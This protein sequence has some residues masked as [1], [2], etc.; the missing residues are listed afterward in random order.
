MAEPIDLSIAVIVPAHNA[1]AYLARC[2]TGLMAAGFSTDEIVLVDDA[3][4]DRTVE[5]ARTFNV[6]P[7][8]IS[9]NAGAANAR[10]VGVRATKADIL[11]FVDADVVVHPD[12]RRRVLAFFTEHPQYAA[13]FGSY[14]DDPAAN[15]VVSRF[16]NLLHRH[17]H[18]EGA[19]K[20]VT[21]W[22]GCGAVRR[23]AFERAG[24]FD[25]KQAM[26]EDIKLGLELT[27]RG[28][29]IWLDPG[30]QGKHL[31]RWTLQS[32]FR[33]DMFHR[34]IPWARMLQTDL[35]EASSYALNLSLKGRLSGIAVA[36][37]LLGLMALL[38][39]PAIGAILIAS[40][41]GLLAYAN[42]S[43]IRSVFAER[44]VFEAAAAIPLLWVHYL[45][46][47][48]GYAWVLLRLP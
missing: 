32:M 5:I 24:G 10:N 39:A 15:T 27:T 36:A 16:R 42:G 3:S 25:A 35:G 11:F 37:S 46:A 41:F 33:T 20:A 47:C 12:T 2:L 34:A 21:F 28:E 30:I 22:T 14:D 6:E 13:V 17:V 7:L 31:K 29:T 1:K 8:S 19:G 45:A 23:E 48:L 40:A 4:T 44:G 38:I 43:F 9:A 26:M 18:I